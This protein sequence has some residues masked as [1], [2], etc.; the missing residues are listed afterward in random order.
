M[1][2][3]EVKTVAKWAID[4]GEQIDSS[5]SDGWQWKDLLSFTDDF[6]AAPG[7]AKSAPAA[8]AAL[9]AGLSDADRAEFVEFVKSELDIPHKEAEAKVEATIEWLISTDKFIRLFLKKKPV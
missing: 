5:F 9:K 3:Q 6:F 2:P 1:L 4:F 7:M 8:L